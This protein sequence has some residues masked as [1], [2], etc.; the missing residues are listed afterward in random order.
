MKR[1]ITI[2][3][4]R[5]GVL[6]MLIFTA[7][8][9]RADPVLIITSTP[10]QMI[11]PEGI[12]AAFT[13][14]VINTSNRFITVK[15]VFALENAI[16]LGGDRNDEVSIIKTA[17]IGCVNTRLGPGGT[18]MFAVIALT[19]DLHPELSDT[20]VGLWRIPVFATGNFD[21]VSTL[22]FGSQDVFVIVRDPVPEPST[23]LLLGTGLAAVVIK[24]R[25]RRKGL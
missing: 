24:I 6:A 11:V 9:L 4:F 2:L 16:F 20:N 13:L 1:V 18:C 8:T 10:P 25:K 17:D 3:V 15:D 19:R 14:T 7:E 5:L 22:E 21:G 12:P 23:M